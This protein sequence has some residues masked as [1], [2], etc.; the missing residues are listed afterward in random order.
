[1]KQEWET[2]AKVAATSVDAFAGESIANL[3][4]AAELPTADSLDID[5]EKSRKQ[6]Q[7]S[8]AIVVEIGGLP[9]K[10]R[11]LNLFKTQE[12]IAKYRKSANCGEIASFTFLALYRS[13]IVPL[14]IWNVPYMQGWGNHTFV[15]IGHP[16]TENETQYIEN[17]EEDNEMVIC[18]PWMKKL[19]QLSKNPSISAVFNPATYRP[20]VEDYTFG[21]D[22]VI[23]VFNVT[24]I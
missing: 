6:L 19:L 21:K 10:E 15:T 24:E 2:A 14:S 1:M 7:I 20:L 8:Q 4:E 16:A 23:N 22:K 3:A 13:G 18:D 9:E 12:R 11:M 5:L 17:W